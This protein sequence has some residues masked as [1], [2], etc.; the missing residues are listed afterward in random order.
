MN[1]NHKPTP[2]Q[3]TPQFTQRIGN[4]VYAV[5]VHFNQ[6][7]KETAEDKILRLMESEVRKS[8]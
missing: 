4:T 3:D 8:A 5:S 2:P 6:S 7:S 1:Q